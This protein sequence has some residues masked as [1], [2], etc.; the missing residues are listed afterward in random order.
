MSYIQE[1]AFRIIDVTR[2]GGF[3]FEQAPLPTF[4]LLYTKKVGRLSKLDINQLAFFYDGERN[5]DELMLELYGKFLNAVQLNLSGKHMYR[6]LISLLNQYNDNEYQKYYCDLVE[7]MLTHLATYRGR[8]M[9]EFMQPASV[10]SLVGKIV[11][12]MH[13]HR[14][15]NPF[16]GLCSY[17]FISDCEYYGQEKDVDTSLLARVRLDAHGKNPDL[18]RWEDSLNY[19]YNI[20][21]DCLVSTPPFGIKL[22]GAYHSHGYHLYRSIEE[23][24]LFNFLESPMQKAVLIMPMSVCFSQQLFAARKTII[25]RNALEMV[26][27]LP[28]GIFYATGVKTVMIVLNRHRSSNRITLVNG[29]ECIVSQGKTKDLDVE[30]ILKI[31]NSGE[32]TH[33]VIINSDEMF[34]NDASWLFSTYASYAE[35]AEEGKMLM[36]LSDVVVPGTPIAHNETSGIVLS[37][38]DFSDNINV[39]FDEISPK[40]DKVTPNHKAYQGKHI[41]LSVL[42]NKVK[43]C[44]CDFDE[45][46]YLNQNQIAFALKDDSPISFEYLV[47]ALLNSSAI[48]RITSLVNGISVR[49]TRQLVRQILECRM[50]VHTEHTDR[51]RVVSTVYEAYKREK[52][53]AMQMEMQ[54]LGIRDASSDLAHILGASFHKISTAINMLQQEVAANDTKDALDSIND[55]FK[56]IQRMIT[57]VGADFESGRLKLSNINVNDF[58]KSYIYSW[59]NFGSDIFELSYHSNVSDDTYI[60]VDADMFRVLFD[61]ILRNAYKHGFYAQGTPDNKV[62]ITTSFVRKEDRE[63][64]LVEFANNGAPFPKGFDIHQYIKRGAFAG[65]TG[66][67]GLGGY[68]IYSIV[69][70]HDGF[71]NLADS[72]AWPVIIEVLIPVDVY[73]EIDTDKFIDYGNTETCI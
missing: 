60:K 34:H 17:A 25:E 9:G 27:E 45:P 40:Q 32:T 58:V 8:Y 36:P 50:Q 73:G 63:Y 10:T 71:L 6:E 1:L 12:D 26:V 47:Y 61:T 59:R 14:I 23:F 51:E 43:L 72:K 13:P 30:A 3:S 22:N 29:Q 68:H 21:A 7:Y 28:A 46:I 38:S 57:T 56:Y 44:V 53:I 62:E 2:R 37:P 4:F 64:I 24:L 65:D 35:E 66:N 41:V 33:R 55:N 39:L 18:L 52:S 15:Y 48:Q 5:S 70:R 11:N 19:W 42:Q 54:R 49:V 67:T 69:K 16:A 20:S 31:I